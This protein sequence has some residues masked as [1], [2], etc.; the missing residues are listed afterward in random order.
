MRHKPLPPQA[1]L[2][3]RLSYEPSTGAF[4]WI[5]SK[6]VKVPAGS[7]AG[8]VMNAGYVHIQLDGVLYL[9]HRLAWMFVTGGD[10]GLAQVDH[11]NGV[12]ADNR[13]DNLRLAPNGSKDNT[14]NIRVRKDSTSGVTGVSFDKRKQQ[15]HA[16]IAVDRKL[17]TIGFFPSLESAAEARRAAK[18]NYHKFCSED[19][20]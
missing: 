17:H 12:Y 10:P 19:R 13:W 16:Y 15:W 11:R 7:P 6:T 14:Q 3:A 20:V 4:S 8:T 9:G 18:P 1:V 5:D 2:Q